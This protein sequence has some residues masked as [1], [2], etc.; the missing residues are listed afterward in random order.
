MAAVN[1][2][3]RS[4]DVRV[5]SSVLR[6]AVARSGADDASGVILTMEDVDG[7]APPRRTG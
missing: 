6:G 7:G 4:I 3:G 1:R 5:L 2:R